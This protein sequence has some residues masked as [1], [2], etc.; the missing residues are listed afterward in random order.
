MAGIRRRASQ[1][2]ASTGISVRLTTIETNSASVRAMLK[3]LEELSHHALD[4]SQRHED[5]D[6]GQR[7]ADHRAADLAAG[8]V[9]GRVAGL[10][11]RQMP[12]DVL[13]HHHRS[14]MIR[15][16]ATASPPND[17]KFS[18]SPVNRGTRN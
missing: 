6:R 5:Q 2:A 9:D 7:R 17:I 11:F 12:G 14:S 3:R 8:R 15:P 10:A 4:K 1:R 18:V 13:H 16:I